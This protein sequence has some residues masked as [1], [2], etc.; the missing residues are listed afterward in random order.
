MTSD[1]SKIAADCF[2]KGNEAMAKGNWDYCIQMYQQAALFV[3]ENLLFRQTLRGAEY[4]K[5]DNNKTGARMAAVKL[6]GTRGKIKKAKMKKDWAA[7][8]Q[9]VEQGLA[10]NPWDAQ[11]NADLGEACQNLGYAEVAI[12]A[13]EKAVEAEPNNKDYNRAL[14]ELYHQRGRYDDSARIWKR[15]QKI[16]PMDSEA[17]TKAT[18]VGAESV[19][20]RGGYEGAEDI[21][22]VM[23][24]HETSKRLKMGD[25]SRAADGPGMSEEADLQRAARKEPDN[26]D[27]YLRLASYYKREGQL[28]EMRAALEKALEL[29]DGDVSIE[30]QVEDVQLDQMRHE[31]D[32]AKVKASQAPDDEGARQTTVELAKGLLR[33]ELEVLAKRV[34][35]YPAD[36]RIKYELA[37]RYARVKKYKEAIPLFQ[38]S[39][40]DSRMAAE[41]LVALADC[42]I[43]E[44]K[45]RL[46]QRQ[47]EKAVPLID[48]HDQ[49]DLFK[50][51]HYLLGRLCEEAGDVEAAEEHYGEVLA[52][53]YEYKDALT[54]LEGL[55]G[56]GAS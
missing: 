1:K 24:D 18:Q 10:I 9:T 56:D 13:Y 3:P 16:D 29:S 17:R 43:R 40:K 50:R 26:K 19:M 12:D 7:L 44:K 47:L 11:L 4:R 20:D 48:Q 45:G 15:I 27:N 52:L 39:I 49:P 21:K 51:A 25:K 54:R 34:Q 41:G 32:A 2:R 33:R 42:F 38:Q 53:D 37:Q 30:E 6:M 14:A 8:N 55:Q 23:A 31:A 28:E 46:A 5:Y 22:G 36:L 35:R